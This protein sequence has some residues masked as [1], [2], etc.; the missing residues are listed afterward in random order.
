[1]IAGINKF[2]ILLEIVTAIKI[3]TK[4]KKNATTKFPIKGIYIK[5]GVYSVNMIP[6][7]IAIIIE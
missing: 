2:C 3:Q 5:T 7:Q 1:M 4:L 6:L